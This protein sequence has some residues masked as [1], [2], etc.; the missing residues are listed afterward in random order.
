MHSLHSLAHDGMHIDPGV[1]ERDA[2]AANDRG[3]RG[4]GAVPAAR[5]SPAGRRLR[6]RRHR[7]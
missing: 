3:A 2:G 6:S 4:P 1:E 5:G 7:P